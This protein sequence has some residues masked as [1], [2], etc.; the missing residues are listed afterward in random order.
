MQTVRQCSTCA[1]RAG[2]KLLASQRNLSSRRGAACSRLLS[3]S[4]AGVPLSTRKMATMN[5][6]Q[7][8][9]SAHTSAVPLS[10]SHLCSSPSIQQTEHLTHD[11]LIRRATLLVAD[12]NGTL[13]SQSTYA[14]VDALE[15]YAKAVHTRIAL[16]RRHLTMLGKLSTAE[17]DSLQRAIFEQK[18]QVSEHL[19]ECKRFETTWIKAINLCK[20]AAEVA[21]TSGSEQ[22]SV[23]MTANIQLAQS[24]ADQARQAA[25]GAD[26]KLAETKVDEIQRMAE[27]AASLEDFD[28]V[29]VNEAYLR[30]D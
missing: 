29:Q 22:A 16:Q 28:E 25:A 23:T 6:A 15:A 1:V 17:E 2:P 14:L 13:L 9:E 18:A 8:K 26:K 12:G 30:E 19:D 3:G 7:W 20:I 27:Y 4:C 21:Y 11:A 10:M 5:L 24:H